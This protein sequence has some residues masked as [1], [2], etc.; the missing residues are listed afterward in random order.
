MPEWKNPEKPSILQG[1]DVKAFLYLYRQVRTDF[2]SGRVCFKKM[3]KDN[4]WLIPIFN[5][6]QSDSK[7]AKE[8]RLQKLSTN[9]M[10][11]VAKNLAIDIIDG[12]IDR[13]EISKY[14]KDYI[15]KG[16]I[17]GLEHFAV[18][19]TKSSLQNHVN[20]ILQLYL[21][22]GNSIPLM[23]NFVK[24]TE[25]YFPSYFCECYPAHFVEVGQ[26]PQE[27]KLVCVPPKEDKSA[28]LVMVKLND[29]EKFTEVTR[30]DEICN[31]AVRDGKDI[32]ISHK[33]GVP[34]CFSLF[35]TQDQ[36]SLLTLLC[37]YYRLTEK[38][39]FSLCNQ[40]KS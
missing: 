16:M 18:M 19:F 21:Q 6:I 9:M 35:K 1:V 22:F 31:I 4:R 26:V 5:P 33:N 32:E 2:E 8:E 29:L 20:R 40:V 10:S 36:V 3:E 34:L 13:K 14:Y 39:T 37:S 30:I 27:V 12:K 7:D 25:K 11:L 28:S 38:W 15:P 23:D 24:L 17:E